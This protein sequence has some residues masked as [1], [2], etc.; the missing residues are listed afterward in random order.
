MKK[1]RHSLTF[2]LLIGV[3][4]FAGGCGEDRPVDFVPAEDE[5]DQTIASFTLRQTEN[6]E[7]TWELVAELA[8][9]WDKENLTIANEPVVDFYEQGEHQATL[10]AHEGT[11]NMLSND[12]QARG[13]VV[14][15][16]ED[17]AELRTEVLNWDSRRERLFTEQPV[18][19]IKAG[20]EI[21]GQGFESDPDLTDWQIREPS[22]TVAAEELGG[23][24]L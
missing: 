5:P 17:G 12:M 7:L 10:T 22:G 4:L 20:T 18:T 15:V 16:A 2:F 1:P 21:T 19:L 9:I 14:V 8:L 11:V 24:T 3:V 13:G 6:G 23:Q